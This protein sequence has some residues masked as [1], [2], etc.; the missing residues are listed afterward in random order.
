[1]QPPSP[2]LLPLLRL[3]YNYPYPMLQRKIMPVAACLL[4][5]GSADPA[6]LTISP[7]TGSGRPGEAVTISGSGYP[8]SATALVSIGGVGTVP[9]A[10]RT[11]AGGDLPRTVVILAGPLA[12]GRHRATVTAGTTHAFEGAFSVRPVIVLDPPIGDGKAGATWRTNEAIAPGGYA[13]MV[14]VVSGSG[15]PGGSFVPGDSI[16]VGEAPTIHDPLRVGED[17]VLRSTTVVVGSDLPAGR[18]DLAMRAGTERIA[19][20]AMFHVAPWAATD[21]MRQR[22]AARALASARDEIGALVR[23]HGKFLPAEET[24]GLNED[25]NRS[26]AALKSGD[27]QKSEDISREVKDKVAVLAGQAKKA[28]QDKLTELADVVAAGFDKLQPPGS[29]PSRQGAGTIKQGRKTLADAR[30]AIARA[31]F[32]AAQTLLKAAN[33]T[34]KKA[35][36]EAGVPETTDEQIRW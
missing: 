6:N 16:T 31:D 28:R 30:E 10:V 19:F 29:P 33:A 22:A 20:P 32:E 7:N 1:M 11:G 12:A 8:A 5:C 17:G 26:S 13:G 3:R 15:F 27:F 18:Y 34:L 36:E 2:R 35:Q 24:A 14:F 4:I 9:E 23:D 25:V 21:E